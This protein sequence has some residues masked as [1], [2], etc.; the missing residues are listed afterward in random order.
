MTTPAFS[1]RCYAKQVGELRSELPQAPAAE[2]SETL[3]L[4]AKQ[5]AIF[6]RASRQPHEGICV[7]DFTSA[8]T[9][10]G[11]ADPT[12]KIARTGSIQSD[13][14]TLIGVVPDGVA[15]VTLHY[16]TGNGLPALTVTTNVVGNLFAVSIACL[17]DPSFEL[18]PDIAWRAPNGRVSRRSRRAK[19][20]SRR[21]GSGRS[22]D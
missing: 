17:T 4:Q 16:P 15:S 1:P 22:S 9:G 20:A 2:R 6:K 5:I 12:S 19:S 11:N 3:A 21:P 10:G 13:N 8:G 18:Q 7:F 14:S